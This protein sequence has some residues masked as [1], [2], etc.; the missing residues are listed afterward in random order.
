MVPFLEGFLSNLNAVQSKQILRILSQMRDRGEIRNVTEF[1]EELAKLANLV[2]DGQLTQR[3]PLLTF[4]EGELLESDAIRTF[5][6]HVRLDLEAALGETERLSNSMR[7]HNRILVENYFDSIEAS[8]AELE[9]ETRAYEVLE[10]RKYTG[11]NSI[12]KR[13]TFDGSISASGA[14]KTDTDVSSL[15]VDSRGKEDLYYSPP[16]HGELGLHLGF[17]GAD[18]ESV[19]VF[20]K[21]EMLTDSTTPQTSLDIS[22]EENTPIKAIDGNKDTAWK[23][24]I[25][26]TEN[27]DFCR[28]ILAPSFIGA[29]RV[30]AIVIEPI[31][32]VT[33]KLVSLSYTNSGG[34]EVSLP[35]GAD[36]AGTTSTL[37]EREGPLGSISIKESDWILPNRRKIIPVGDIVARKFTLTLQQD[38]ASDGDFFYREADLKKWSRG[39]SVEECIDG[40]LRGSNRVSGEEIPYDFGFLDLIKRRKH[41]RRQARFFEYVFGFKDISTI[42]R[43]YAA[44]GLFV[45]EPFKVSNPPNILALYSDAEFPANEATDVEFLLRKENYGSDKLLLDVETIPILPYGTSLVTERLF[46]TEFQTGSAIKNEG[47]LRFYPDFSSSFTVSG[48]TTL[49]VGSD[50]SI[51]ID[52]GETFETSLPPSSTPIDPAKCLVR[53]SSPEPGTVYTI[54]YTPLVSTSSAG[55]EVWLNVDHTVRLGRY[56]TYVFNNQRSTGSVSYCH[57]GLQ[58]I[59]RANTLNT[60]VSPY[61]REAVLLG[62]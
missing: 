53:I 43:E 62:G 12:I 17:A 55:G 56:Q 24:S 8:L 6:E 58:I 60:R 40:F 2:Q 13:W 54:S 49:T 20:N 42:T 45:V 34:S 38:T 44:N 30:N 19:N 27:P 7:A 61:L 33:M 1:E 29:R 39:T 26:L 37:L 11:F 47:K 5:V 59:L 4:E 18:K 32:D 36:Y 9:A 14:D 35:I 28:L 48:G 3:T 52:G 57:L 50:Y 22:M 25:L 15:F 23:H 21:I 41:Q 46:L 10:T 51:S 31:S 16:G